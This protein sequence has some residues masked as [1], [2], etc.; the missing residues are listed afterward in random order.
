MGPKGLAKMYIECFLVDFVFNGTNFFAKQL[1]I[2]A[3]PLI[4]IADGVICGRE[5]PSGDI[6]V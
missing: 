6:M 3:S 1:P 4:A 5:I 2:Y